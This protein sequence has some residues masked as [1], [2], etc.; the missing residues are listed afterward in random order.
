MMTTATK[1][2]EGNTG[3][4]IQKEKE[5]VA[6]MIELYCQKKHKS[7]E[8]C[9]ECQALL[10]YAHKRLTYCQFGEEKKA[11]SN[12]PIHCYK[13]DYR[14]QIKNVM[15]YAGPRMLIYHPIYSFRH[16]KWKKD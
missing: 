4:V 16:L 15:R 10:D 2:R 12:C 8:L 14:E 1:K 11:C 7:T 5:T 9:E 6:K 13:P 3:P